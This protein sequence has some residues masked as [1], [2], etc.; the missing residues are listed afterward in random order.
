MAIIKKSSQPAQKEVG[1]LRS[2]AIVKH[3]GGEEVIV[4]VI[5]EYQPEKGQKVFYFTPWNGKY[6]RAFLDQLSDYVPDEQDTED[7][8]FDD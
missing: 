2:K 6:G 7:I 3:I 5:R 4:G 1:V 8:V